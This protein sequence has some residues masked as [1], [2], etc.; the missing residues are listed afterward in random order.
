MKL[1]KER[2]HRS[3]VTN[4]VMTTWRDHVPSRCHDRSRE[5]PL[6]YNFVTIEIYV[7]ITIFLIIFP[8][9]IVKVPFPIGILKSKKKMTVNTGKKCAPHGSWGSPHTSW[10]VMTFVT[11]SWPVMTVQV[12]TNTDW[13]PRHDHGHQVTHGHDHVMT[14]RHKVVTNSKLVTWNH[15]YCTD[16]V[17][18]Y[19]L[20]IMNR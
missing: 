11:K 12:V 10:P 4:F 2:Y 8:P 18:I 14:S 7:Q 19:L 13:T 1:I 3:K 17:L 16:I 5:G 15:W 9:Q 20:F 6:W